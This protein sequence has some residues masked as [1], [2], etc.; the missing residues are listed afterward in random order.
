M[1]SIIEHFSDF[2]GG[3]PSILVGKKEIIIKKYLI[4]HSPYGAFQG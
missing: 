3:L 4:I 1:M 2:F